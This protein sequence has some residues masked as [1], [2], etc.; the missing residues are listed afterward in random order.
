MVIENAEKFG[1]SQLHQL[2][3]RVGR[4]AEKSFCI[5][6]SGSKLNNDARERLKIMCATNDGFRIAEKDLELRGPGDIEGTRQSGALN[7]KLASI[8]QD[9]K[10][11][12]IA[13]EMAERLLDADPDLASATN[14]QLKNYLQS[15]K[16][17]T[18]WSK[19]S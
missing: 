18:A 17:K 19:I 7:F 9:K 4:G 8:V 10:W 15:L 12:E 3:G 13:R 11:L 1:L 2:R 14:L 5:L 6:L 16:G